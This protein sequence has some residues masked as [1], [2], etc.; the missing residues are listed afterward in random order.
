M[1]DPFDPGERVR[2]EFEAILARATAFARIAAQ[3]EELERRRHWP[4]GSAVERA[5]RE[6]IDREAG[7]RAELE[8]HVAGQLCRES[9][10]ASARLLIAHHPDV[11]ARIRELQ[12]AHTGQQGTQANTSSS[13]SPSP[14]EETS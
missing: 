2:A 8:R 11:V 12:D 3:E 10:A 7:R 1:F 14:E 9:A 13:E 4:Y 6:P 5:I